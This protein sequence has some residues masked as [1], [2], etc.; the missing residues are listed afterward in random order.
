M[1]GDIPRG[2]YEYVLSR[3]GALHTELHLAGWTEKHPIFEFPVKPAPPKPEDLKPCPNCHGNGS[4]QD[5]GTFSQFEDC[6]VC[7][8]TGKVKK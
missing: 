3:H 1:R 4:V 2:A 5:G 6:E 7:N 8:G